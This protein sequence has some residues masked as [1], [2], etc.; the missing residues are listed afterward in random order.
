MN[1]PFDERMARQGFGVDAYEQVFYYRFR[2]AVEAAKLGAVAAL[3]RSIGMG[4]NRL[5]HTGSMRYDPNVVKIPTAAVATEDAD[6]MA[7]LGSQGPIKMRLVLTPKTLPDADSY[8][9]VAD[10]PGVQFPD[11]FVL[12]S[13]HL[14]SWDL[15]TGALDDAAGV[16]M[17]MQT[18]Y[19][20]KRLGLQPSRTIRMVAWTGEENGSPGA[21]A[22]AEL[23]KAHIARHFAAIESDLGAGRPLGINVI[24]NPKLLELLSPVAQ[25]LEAQG[26]GIL[27]ISENVDADLAPLHYAGIP[28]FS[29]IQDSRTYFKYHHSAADTFDKINP[30]ELAENASVMAVLAY[31]LSE[32]PNPPPQ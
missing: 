2:T 16:A 15:G 29:L 21:W 1:K 26:A 3:V 22:Y 4:G 19:L 9:V 27:R 17:S 25:T 8:N 6:L 23:H 24:G 28:C 10:L 14:D 31:G 7:Y 30:S 18:I 32:L 5:P 12:V 20:L 13:G 11:Q